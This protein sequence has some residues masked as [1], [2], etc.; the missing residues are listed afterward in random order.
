LNGQPHGV[1]VEGFGAVDVRH[2]VEDV[3]DAVLAFVS[4]FR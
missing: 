2:E 4:I 3:G 1:P